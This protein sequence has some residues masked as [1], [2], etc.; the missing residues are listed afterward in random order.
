MQELLIESIRTDNGVQSR[1]KINEEYVAELA[2]NIKAGAT[3]PP[4]EVF[5]DGS[6]YWAADGFHR[7]MAHVR[8][9]K[10]TIKAN[11]HKGTH[12]D[13]VWASCGANYSHGLRRTTLDKQ[14]AVAMAL[15]L[16]PERSDRLLAEHVKVGHSMVS[17]ARRQVSDSDNSNVRNQTESRVG[18]D[19]KKYP[20]PPPCT[21]NQPTAKPKDP[22]KDY[23]GNVIPDGLHGLFEREHEVNAVLTSLSTITATLTKAKASADPLYGDVN[24][25]QATA[26]LRTAYDSIK[27][28]APYAVCPWCHGLTADTCKGCGK[29][30]VLGKYRWEHTVPQE[31]KARKT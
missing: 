5:H 29:R 1:V 21:P 30:G 22:V 20:P 26:G 11:V 16:H 9:G 8:I 2:E 27:A 24:F 18:R 31:M 6:E 7:I 17:A 4:V 25:Q 14:H 23:V 19:G 15:R 12:D 10:R 3:L 13:A 28:T